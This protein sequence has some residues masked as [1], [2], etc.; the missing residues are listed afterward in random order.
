MGKYFLALIFNRIHAINKY[1]WIKLTN[2]FTYKIEIAIRNQP[3]LYLLETSVKLS[4]YSGTIF[5]LNLGVKVNW[6]I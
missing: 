1:R 6:M 2:E 3:I 4:E 5:K